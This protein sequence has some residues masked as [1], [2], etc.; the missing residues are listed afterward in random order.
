DGQPGACA[1]TSLVCRPPQLFLCFGWWVVR[2]DGALA[3]HN[4]RCTESRLPG[5]ARRRREPGRS[6]LHSVIRDHLET[7]LAEARDRSDDGAGLPGFVEDELLLRGAGLIRPSKPRATR[8]T[9]ADRSAIRGCALARRCPRAAAVAVLRRSDA[10]AQVEV[11]VG[12]HERLDR[13]GRDACH[14]LDAVGCAVVTVVP[15]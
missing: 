4:E 15:V 13:L 6:V 12:R 8:S 9:R 2:G 10:S 11:P 14:A 3:L 7:F 1:E 5:G